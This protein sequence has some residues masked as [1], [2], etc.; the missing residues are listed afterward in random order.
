MQYNFH[1]WNKMASSG[2]SLA[3]QN[4]LRGKLPVVVCVG[5]DLTIGD[6]VGPVCGSLLTRQKQAHLF[7][8]GTL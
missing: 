1:I 3:L 4:F 6:S 7:V 5:S 8:Y 2:I